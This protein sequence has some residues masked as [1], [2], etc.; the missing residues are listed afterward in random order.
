MAKKFFTRIGISPF[1]AEQHIGVY[2]SFLVNIF[3]SQ[4][5]GGKTLLR[6]DDTNPMHTADIG[7]LVDDMTQ[8]IDPDLI[9]SIEGVEHK[10]IGRYSIP[11][12]FQSDRSDIYLKYL[13]I[14][15]DKG[16]LLSSNGATYLNVRRF[17]ELYGDRICL[18]FQGK[19]NRA[20]LISKSLPNLSFPLTVDYG[21]RFLWHFTSVVDDNE[22]SVTH[23][24]RA[25]DKI[26]NQVPQTILST[27]LGFDRPDYFYTKIM[28]SSHF[29]PTINNITS[30]GVSIEAIKSYLYGTITGKSEE[31][32]R[33]FSAA[34]KDFSPVSILPGIFYFDIKKIMS[35]E[36]MLQNKR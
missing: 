9:S 36:R 13:K 28:Q 29:V 10:H 5:Y 20:G 31:L 1:S 34:L 33:S 21:K 16:F 15:E 4:Y 17:I 24:V 2:R 11:A 7:R 27:I 30:L 23:V 3:I 19:P 25:M 8:I 18:S 35:I 22:F 12:I 6:I 14:I 26:D 32:Y